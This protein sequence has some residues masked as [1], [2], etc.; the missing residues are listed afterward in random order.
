ACAFG[1]F[2]LKSH[3]LICGPDVT[4]RTIDPSDQFVVMGSDGVWD[5]LSNAEVV[6]IVANTW[7]RSKA[8]KQVAQKAVA[9]WAAEKHANSR[10]D[11]SV[12]VLF[13]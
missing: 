10:D 5:V 12:A 6:E 8:A 9:K 11:I 2:E 1:D 3:G 13:F 4:V 7:P